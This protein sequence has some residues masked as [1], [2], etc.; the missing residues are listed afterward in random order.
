MQTGAKLMCPTVRVF[1]PTPLRNGKP[2][3]V[4]QAAAKRDLAE[5]FTRDVLEN[6]DRAD[7]IAALTPEEYAAQRGRQVNP[8]S[9]RKRGRTSMQ[10]KVTQVRPADNPGVLFGR[11]AERAMKREDAT[12][13]ENQEL[14][15]SVEALQDK[16]EEIADIASAAPGQNEDQD[17]LIEKLNRILDLA[18]PDAEPA[19]EFDEEE[20]DE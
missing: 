1:N 16:L 9:Q 6:D 8:N 12:R 15:A 10:R 4:Q 14:K 11:A 19:G 5:R 2:W 7:E 3:T 18:D 13:K 20:S 17:Q